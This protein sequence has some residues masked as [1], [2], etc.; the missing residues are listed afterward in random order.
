[1]YRHQYIYIWIAITCC[2]THSNT[3]C[4]MHCNT[5]GNT[6]CNMHCNTRKIPVLMR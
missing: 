2:N 1:M 3:L 6:C 4:N 5:C